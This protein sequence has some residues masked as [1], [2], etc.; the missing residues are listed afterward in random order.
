LPADGSRDFAFRILDDLG[1][2]RRVERCS[3]GS[4]TVDLPPR[5]HDMRFSY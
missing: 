4:V 2:D 3:D 5:M 1:W